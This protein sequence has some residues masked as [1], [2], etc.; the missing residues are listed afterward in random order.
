MSRNPKML[1]IFCLHMESAPGAFGRLVRNEFGEPMALVARNR[2]GEEVGRLTYMKH[3]GPID[4]FVREGDR[5]R[6][7]G[8]ALYDALEAVGGAIPAVEEGRALSCEAQA[9]REAR[10]LRDAMRGGR[11]V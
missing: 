2:A 7:V 11:C 9:L 4:V 6:G 1:G 3:G 10:A 8:M 5:R